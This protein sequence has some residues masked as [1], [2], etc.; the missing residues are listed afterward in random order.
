MP[1]EKT[2]LEPPAEKPAAPKPK[3]GDA[4]YD[5]SAHYDTADL[6]LHTFANGT[7]IALKPFA[8]IYSKTWLYKIRSLQTDVDIEFAAIDRAACDTAKELLLALDDT[9]GDPLDELFK[10]WAAAATARSE[11]EKGMTPGE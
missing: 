6:Y 10:A 3:P 1:K 2:T 5:W 8:S 4:D 11:G 7:V 9:D